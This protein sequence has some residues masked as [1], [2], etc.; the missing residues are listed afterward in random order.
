[1][2]HLHQIGSC[3]EQLPG[4]EHSPRIARRDRRPDQRGG[5]WVDLRLFSEQFGNLARH[6]GA[7][8]ELHGRRA[9]RLHPIPPPDQY[10]WRFCRRRRSL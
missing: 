6:G 10:G 9:V 2:H 1:L 4:P 3:C 7:I 5:A 8:E